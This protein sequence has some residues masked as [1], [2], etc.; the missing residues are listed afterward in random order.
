MIPTF[1]KL[2]VRHG[3][4]LVIVLA[5]VLST[6]GCKLFRNRSDS[7]PTQ[8]DRL[9]HTYPELASGRFAVIADFESPAHME[10]FQLIGVSNDARCTLSRKHGRKATGKHGLMFRAASKSRE[11]SR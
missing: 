7:A 10:L 3:F 2:S 8:T 6:S 4:L 5:W 9:M 11:K 1:S